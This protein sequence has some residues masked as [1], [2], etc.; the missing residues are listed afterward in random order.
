MHSMALRRPLVLHAWPGM[1]TKYS[2]LVW[3]CGADNDAMLVCDMC[4]W[5]AGSQERGAGWKGSAPWLSSG[6]QRQVAR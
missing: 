1:A 4:V 5:R 2:G 3:Y 6:A